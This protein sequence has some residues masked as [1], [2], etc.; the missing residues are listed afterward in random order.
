M[1]QFGKK[2]FRMACGISAL[3]LL[4][5]GVLFLLTKS[6]I[7]E[8]IVHIVI[9][10]IGLCVGLWVLQK[11]FEKQLPYGMKKMLFWCGLVLFVDLI[12]VNTVRYVLASGAST[13]LF[14]PISIPLCFLIIMHYSYK[15]MSGDNKKEKRL[16]YIIGIPFLL[17]SLY[18]EVLAFIQI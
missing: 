6:F 7:A 14:L 18:F 12:V 5:L 1:F 13:V 15:V 3:L 2:T 17:L 10:W 11:A 4:F 9:R 8:V 16:T